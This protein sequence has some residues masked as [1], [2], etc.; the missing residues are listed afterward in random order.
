MSDASQAV[1]RLLV[2]EDEYLIRMLLEDMLADLGYDVVAAVGTI[3]EASELA[4][5]GD[6]ADR[7]G[8]LVAEV[9]EHVLQQ[10]ADEIFILDHEKAWHRSRGIAHHRLPAHSCIP[11]SLHES[12]ANV[13]NLR[14]EE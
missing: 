8:H 14:R 10:H 4:A 2:V 5:S 7:R 12:P 3:A 11:A 13:L 1:P 6:G 9:G